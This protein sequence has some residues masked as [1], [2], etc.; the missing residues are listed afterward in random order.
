[1]R[2]LIIFLNTLLCRKETRRISYYGTDRILVFSNTALGDTVLST[3]ALYALRKSFPQS[4]I[5]LIV[6]KKYFYFF[7]GYEHIDKLISYKKNFFGLLFH[8]FYIRK[9]KIGSIFFLH[10]NGPQDLFLSLFS[11]SENILK[12]PNFPNDISDCFKKFVKN[13]TYAYKSKH[14][15]EQRLDL[16]RFFNSNFISTRLNLPSKFNLPKKKNKNIAI[17][18]GAADFYKTWPVEYFVETAELICND[19]GPS[20][21]FSLL[22]VEKEKIL[23]EKFISK[24]KYPNLVKNLCGK[25]TLNNLP[26]VINNAEL[27]ITNDTG[28][29]HLAIA[30]RTPTISIFSPTN[31]KYFGPYQDRKIHKTV[32]IDGSF[33]NN[34][35]KK[36]RTQKAMS[37]ISSD[38]VLEAYF[39]LKDSGLICAE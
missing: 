32:F 7:K 22:G 5:S 37:L 24:F 4:H 3:P 15:I 9:N 33:E 10:S 34:K 2:K 6:N 20:F 36:K 8:I 25:V 31:P 14:I 17:Q 23:A 13:N 21:N 27:L 19:L 16:V 1:M 39:S 29:L 28:T 11:K 35:P 30:L 18:L 38:L 12:A 26:K